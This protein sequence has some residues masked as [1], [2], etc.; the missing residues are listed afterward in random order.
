MGARL[1][2]HSLSTLLP[3][4]AGCLAQ[5]KLSPETEERHLAE[6]WGKQKLETTE[7]STLP[8]H[9]LLVLETPPA[10]TGRLLLVSNPFLL[11]P[12][13]D[14]AERHSSAIF[15]FFS[16]LGTMATLE[17]IHT[18]FSTSP[19]T[20]FLLATALGTMLLLFSKGKTQTII[21][22]I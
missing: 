5:A 9:S 8:P 2:R 20:A 17:C 10:I 4:A 14:Q 11:Y 1:E 13:A 22:K 21:F 19:S 6:G 16:A 18:C 12:V 3:S 7:R 15:P